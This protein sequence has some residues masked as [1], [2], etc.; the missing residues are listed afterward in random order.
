[1]VNLN[2]L[3]GLQKCVWLKFL[4]GTAAATELLAVLASANG[5]EK[6]PKCYKIGCSY[7]IS[8]V[9]SCWKVRNHNSYLCKHANIKKSWS[10][11]AGSPV[12]SLRQ[13]HRKLAAMHTVSLRRGRFWA[14]GDTKKFSNPGMVN[15]NWLVGL[16]KCVWLRFLQ[17]TAA[18]MELL[19]V[20]QVQ[21][22]LK[23][24]QNAI[25]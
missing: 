24:A 8:G 14:C 1:M 25:K 13:P 2:W 5:P 16:Q 20:L 21:T 4:Q 19:A 12:M 3:V 6:G 7:C 23:K 17:G 11:L 18:A 15:L 22:G 10:H 9:S